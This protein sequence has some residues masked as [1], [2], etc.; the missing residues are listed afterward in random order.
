MNIKQNQIFI[1]GF[2]ALVVVGAVI[3]Y[4]V[5]QNNRN[6]NDNST[7][8]IT[9]PE[10]VNEFS[11]GS[12]GISFYITKDFERL[13]DEITKKFNPN[14]I[15]GFAHKDVD[16]VSCYISQTKRTGPGEITQDYLAQGT[17]EAIKNNS[18]DAKL[19]ETKKI[20]I[21]EVKGVKLVVSYQENGKEISQIEYVGTNDELTTFAFC[22]CPESLYDFYRSKF[23]EFLNSIKIIK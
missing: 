17:W 2:I 22:S 7:Q 4:V 19:L 11:D 16:G 3:Y 23:E 5:K 10:N 13:S 1:V 18:D 12:L 15:Y 20:Q 8:E 14:F 9:K 21:G 6:L